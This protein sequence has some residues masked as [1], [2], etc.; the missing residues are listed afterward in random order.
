MVTR[1]TWLL[2]LPRPSGGLLGGGLASLD[3]FDQSFNITLPEPGEAPHFDPGQ[4][5]LVNPLPNRTF[6]A[7]E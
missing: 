4:L 3:L 2:V 5:A 7:G 6:T 1:T